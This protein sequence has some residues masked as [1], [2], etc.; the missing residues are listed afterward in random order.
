[1]EEVPGSIPSQ[2][3]I[4]VSSYDSACG[5][6]KDVRRSLF[7]SNP[8][9]GSDIP[10]WRS[11]TLSSVRASVVRSCVLMCFLKVGLD[12]SLLCRFLFY[13]D[14]RMESFVIL[15]VFLRTLH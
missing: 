5:V 7:D 8:C 3:L 2:A 6:I 12:C 4:H 10:G 15:I 11:A 9:P 14:A 13:V 1:M